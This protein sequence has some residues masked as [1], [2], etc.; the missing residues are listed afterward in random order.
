MQFRV[1]FAVFFCK[2]AGF[3]L[4]ICKFLDILTINISLIIGTGFAYG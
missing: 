3:F 2:F 4:H 1:G